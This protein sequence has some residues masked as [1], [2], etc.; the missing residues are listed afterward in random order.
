MSPLPYQGSWPGLILRRILMADKEY[1][2]VFVGGGI[3][4]YFAWYTGEQG[5]IAAFLFQKAVIL[6]YITFSIALAILNWILCNRE[7][8]K[9][10]N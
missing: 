8:R 1:D 3:S 4:F 2:V 5:G 10:E 6:V 9:P 7:S